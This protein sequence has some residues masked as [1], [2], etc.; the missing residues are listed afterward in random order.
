MTTISRFQYKTLKDSMQEAVLEEADRLTLIV[1]HLNDYLYTQG[2]MPEMSVGNVLLLVHQHKDA[3]DVRT[4]DEW[5][6]VGVAVRK[7]EKAL[8]IFEAY[9]G[10]NGAV[11]SKIKNVF[12]RSQ[13][14]AADESHWPSDVTTDP[15]IHAAA[16][17]YAV[18][19]KFAHL[20]KPTGNDLAASFYRDA[21]IIAIDLTKDHAYC[22]Q[23]TV[24]YAVRFKLY[25]AG[26][27]PCIYP[28]GSKDEHNSAWL[29][30]NA[31]LARLDCFDKFYF[32]A[33]RDWLDKMS[34]PDRLAALKQTQE[35][36]SYLV[37]QVEH[38]VMPTFP[39]NPFKDIRYPEIIR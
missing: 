11:G 37:H 15:H 5:A 30:A 7:G 16:V 17:A 39:E 25:Q 31:Y 14:T 19:C 29:T 6:S 22:L 27:V 24:Y 18:D 28:P 23:D 12:E 35:A 13:T 34:I 3:V 32:D 33:S 38:V 1:E 36:L 9:D 21:N 2:A 20:K 4:Y 8:K 10:H 26:V